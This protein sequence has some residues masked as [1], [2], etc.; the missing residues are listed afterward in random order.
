MGKAEYVH[1]VNETITTLDSLIWDLLK[2]MESKDEDLV[3]A[4]CD[5]L[6]EELNTIKE[7]YTDESL[8]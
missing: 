4:I 8:L 3:V 5:Q 2:A 1:Y 6:I 7:T